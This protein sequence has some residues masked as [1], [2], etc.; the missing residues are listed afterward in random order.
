MRELSL[1]LSRSP[2]FATDTYSCAQADSSYPRL[3]LGD[4]PPAVGVHLLLKSTSC[5]HHNSLY[6]PK[7]S[8][9]ADDLP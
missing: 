5:T 6:Q 8:R 3:H 2:S 4:V 1:S 9:V 7:Y